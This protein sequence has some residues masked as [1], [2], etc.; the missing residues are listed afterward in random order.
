M[1]TNPKPSRP[2]H[3]LGVGLLCLLL[4]LLLLAV[5]GALASVANELRAGSFLAALA[6]FG[7]LVAAGLAGY[8]NLVLRLSAAFP[9]GMR[10]MAIATAFVLVFGAGLLH[11]WLAIRSLVS[12]HAPP[13]SMSSG[14]VSV[15]GDP[16]SSWVVAAYNLLV[17]VLLIGG[18]LYAAYSHR[19][20]AN[21]D[22]ATLL[23]RETSAGGE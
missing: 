21:V 2:L 7:C 19:K 16:A 12:G 17:G 8:R 22:R 5:S 4:S 3:R 18:G 1:L 15:E 20:G 14:I 9:A 13:A 10:R 11:L 23:S 6:A